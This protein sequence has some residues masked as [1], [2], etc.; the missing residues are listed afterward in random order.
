MELNASVIQTLKE[1]PQQLKSFYL[2]PTFEFKCKSV[3]Q[4]SVENHQ[5]SASHSSSIC[6]C[7]SQPTINIHHPLYPVLTA[8][9][10][11]QR[12]QPWD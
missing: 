10:L 8:F 5:P 1:G 11:P 6:S 12:L 4:L 3:I 7:S 2:K 9:S